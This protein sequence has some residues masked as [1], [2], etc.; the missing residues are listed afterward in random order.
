MTGQW[1]DSLQAA[2]GIPRRWL[3]MAREVQLELWNI[4][5]G[6]C[7]LAFGLCDLAFEFGCWIQSRNYPW[8]RRR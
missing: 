8:T 4:V 7:D 5:S 3:S 1:S 2:T 6:I